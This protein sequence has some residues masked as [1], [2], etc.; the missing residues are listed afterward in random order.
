[1]ISR[2]GVLLKLAQ[3]APGDTVCA[4]RLV[5]ALARAHPGR[6]VAVDS[7]GADEFFRF[8]TRVSPAAPD[9]TLVEL[10]YRHPIDAA[11]MGWPLLYLDAPLLSY[12][13]QTGEVLPEPEPFPSLVL[14]PDEAAAPLAGSYWVLAA[15]SK[16]DAPLKQAPAALFETLVRETPEIR[17]LQVGDLE[18]H[19]GGS[20]QHPIEGA[21]CLLG[22][23]S[24]RELLWLVAH[25]AGVVCHLSL[26][27]MLAAAF[28]RPCVVLAGGREPASLHV[29]PEAD[30]PTFRY[31]GAAPRFGCAANGCRRRI[32]AP[33]H[34]VAPYP[35]GWLCDE[36]APDPV[37]GAVG[38][39][40]GAVDPG[41]V[42]G[43]VRALN[44]GRAVS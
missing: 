42:V 9:M 22:G 26:P 41:H 4:S 24:L 2:T 13:R 28:R 43:L 1:M 6:P 29:Y 33:A 20:R 23:T 17:W 35:P 3:R 11:Y 16:W 27:F 32:A 25:A 40:L 37:F 44:T 15:G 10:N 34:A 12:W 38:G 21:E 30:W 19:R 8:D 14:G 5:E 31:L 7:V 36:P 39:C 18:R